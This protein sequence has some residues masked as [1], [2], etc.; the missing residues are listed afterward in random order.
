M[1]TAINDDRND[2]FSRLFPEQQ[3]ALFDLA[4][5]NPSW[6]LNNR[7]RLRDELDADYAAG[8]TANTA[9]LLGNILPRDDAR[10]QSAIDYF[11]NPKVEWVY[12]MRPGE[13]FGQDI[14]QKIGVTEWDEIA[15]LN[16]HIADVN[17]IQSGQRIYFPPPRVMRRS[18]RAP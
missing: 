13:E 1:V 17:R 11:Q 6:L 5:R 14:R 12:Q 10:A 16:Q 15:R 4:Y 18:G 3:A 9:A 2:R 8:T 7:A